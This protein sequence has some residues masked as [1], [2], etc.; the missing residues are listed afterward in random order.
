MPPGEGLPTWKMAVHFS[1]EG[2]HPPTRKGHL[3]V[4]VPPYTS[5][6]KRLLTSGNHVQRYAGGNSLEL[7]RIRSVSDGN[8]CY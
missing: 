3:E 2:S 5:R 6:H 7:S 8:I 4:A 1:L